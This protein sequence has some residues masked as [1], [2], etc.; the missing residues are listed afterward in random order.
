M[1]ST[2]F[3]GALKVDEGVSTSNLTAIA[4]ARIGRRPPPSDWASVSMDCV[5]RTR[6]EVQ[7]CD[8]LLQPHGAL[9]EAIGDR[10][11][12]LVTT[13][14][15]DRI[16]GGA[17]R[18]ALQKTN[19]VS[20]LVL[21]AREETKSMELVAAVCN[22]ALS[23]GLNR[24]GLLI[25]FGGGVCSD[26]VTLSASLIRRGVAH[27]RVP[28]TL[29]GQIDAGIGLKGA[30][31]FCGKKSFVGCFHAPEQVLIDPA[32]LQSLPRRY[33]VSGVAEAIKMGIAR[34]PTLFELI[35]ARAR[36]L[37]TSGF[38]EPA[39]EGRELLQRSVWG[40]LDELRQN[41]YEDQ[42]YERLVD[43]GHTFSPALEAALGFDIQHGEAV[44]IDMALSTTIARS[45]GLVGADVWQRIVN[46]L[47]IASLPIF[48][49]RLDFQLCRDALVE[50]RRHRGGSMNLVVPAG[51]GRVVFLKDADDLPDSVLESSLQSLSSCA[52]GIS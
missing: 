7:F 40:M 51:L 28:T 25:S 33:L 23:H 19:T 48:A 30:V 27:I 21:N 41:P 6:Y 24:T 4:T 22:E 47:R 49:S 26:V 35:E 52:A 42:G 39:A 20:T 13:P 12:L 14:T 46:V 44:A 16:H 31:N 38:D 37:V 18:A 2:T 29:I 43:F 3:D 5:A 45:L 11:A 10:K 36:D 9:I 34:D 17:I 8:S 50:A 1:R 15:V 32:F